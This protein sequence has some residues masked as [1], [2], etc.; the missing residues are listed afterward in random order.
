MCCCWH[1]QYQY[2]PPSIVRQSLQPTISAW[3]VATNSGTFRNPPVDKKCQ[4]SAMSD[5]K[6]QVSYSLHLKRAVVGEH[7]TNVPGREF[8]SLAKKHKI[9]PAAIMLD[10]YKRYELEVVSKNHQVCIRVMRRH[11]GAGRKPHHQLLEEQLHAWVESRNKKPPVLKASS[12]WLAKFLNRF[13][14]V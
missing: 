4:R 1:L 9:P 5:D 14:L 7:A 10:W 12:D 11:P 2:F 3:V 8:H 6:K 13:N